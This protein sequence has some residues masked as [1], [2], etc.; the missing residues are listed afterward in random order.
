VQFLPPGATDDARRLLTTRGLR[1]VADGLVS[2][3]LAP[4]L[5]V[6]G[7]SG[8]QVGAVTT[9]TLLGSAAM[10]LAVGLRGHRFSR[11]RLLI[12]VSILMITTGFVFSVASSYTLI[13]IA[14]FLGTMNPSSGDVSVFLPTEQ[15]LLPATVP[16]RQRTAVF[17]RFSLIAFACGAI[18]SIAATYPDALVRLGWLPR[19]TA[20][21]SVFLVYS[22]LGV[23]ALYLYRRVSPAV[24]PDLTGDTKRRSALNESRSIVLRLAAVFSIDSLGGGFAVQ[25]IV[26]LW[27]SLRWHL[28]LSQIGVLFF[29]TGMCSGVST[30]LAP[31]IAAR[32]GLVRTMVYTHLPANALLMS[33]AFMPRSSLAVACLVARSLL[34]QM[35]APARQ[36]YV[37]AVVTPAE[38]PAAASVTN[39]PR[40]LASA[41]PPVLAGRLLEHSTFGWPLLIGGALKATYDIILLLLFRNVHPPEER[42]EQR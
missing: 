3:A 34:S 27:L 25:S 18:G 23:C 32:I 12:A 39:V 21:R 36:S 5:L 17:A 31:R 41:L 40:S 11:R 7:F 9:A 30:L 35:D 24:E 22:L 13:L 1:A 33:A 2:T 14:A 26:G 6:L 15:A 37:M 16:D 8:S 20:I 28:S 19:T 42:S 38:R 29:V 4:Y 10:T